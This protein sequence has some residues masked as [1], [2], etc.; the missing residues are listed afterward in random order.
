MVNLYIY[1]YILCTT[2][3]ILVHLIGKLNRI[4]YNIKAEFIQYNNRWP[5]GTNTSEENGLLISYI[6]AMTPLHGTA[7]NGLKSMTDPHWPDYGERGF[8]SVLLSRKW[9]TGKR[10]TS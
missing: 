4:K 5:L 6:Q 10:N 3:H 1:I 8:I 7:I 9:H 2:L